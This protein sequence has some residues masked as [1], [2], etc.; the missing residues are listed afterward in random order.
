MRRSIPVFVATLVVLTVPVLAHHS[1]S[2]EFDGSKAVTLA[3]G[4]KIFSGSP[5]D[6]GPKY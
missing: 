3:D 4:R 6:G 5:D 2:A 1:F